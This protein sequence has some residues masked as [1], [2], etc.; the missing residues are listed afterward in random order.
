MTSFSQKQLPATLYWLPEWLIFGPGDAISAHVVPD[1]GF[2]ALANQLTKTGV[3]RVN[4]ALACKRNL[5]PG[6]VEK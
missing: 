3:N 4:N 5:A 6:H 1:L 2:T